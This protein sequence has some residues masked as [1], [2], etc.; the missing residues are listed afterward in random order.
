MAKFVGDIGFT[1]GSVE[2][3]PGSGKYVN[4]IVE[5]PYFGDLVRSAS[6]VDDGP[7]V[8]ANLVLSNSLSIVADPYLM[9]HYSAIR[10][11]KW[12]GVYWVVESVTDD[13]DRPRLT[14]R[15]GGVYNGPK[16]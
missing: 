16:A 5:R 8:N 9:E 7:G 2:T 13:P 15:L 12:A 14:I 1:L 11:V 10:Y 6:R 4:Q 3:P